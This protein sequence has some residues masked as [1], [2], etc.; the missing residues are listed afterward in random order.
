M[1]KGAIE[2]AVK[3]I[4][5]SR[6][7]VSTKDGQKLIDIAKA[8]KVNNNYP[9]ILRK[10][11]VVEGDKWNQ[12]GMTDNDLAL[13]MKALA[14]KMNTK[15]TKDINFSIGKSEPKKAAAKPK[16]KEQPKAVIPS[17]KKESKQRM[18]YRL[19]GLKVL[20]REVESV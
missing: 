2:R 18:V 19:F 1:K 7:S 11:G 4:R 8:N 3:F 12:Q 10:M 5:A 9:T 6:K 14:S 13:N 16:R 20:T 15:S 17:V